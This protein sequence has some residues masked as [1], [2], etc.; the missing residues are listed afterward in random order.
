MAAQVIHSFAVNDFRT[1]MSA[2]TRS[3]ALRVLRLCSTL[4]G[5]YIVEHVGR[6]LL[7]SA[8]SLAANFRSACHAKSSPDFFSK[9][10]LCEEKSIVS[11]FWLD[12]IIDGQLCEGSQIESLKTE[13]HE[14]ASILS[15]TCMTLNNRK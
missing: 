6:Q 15:K 12:F 3:F 13:A 7:R 2:R 9:L 1:D 10:K 8:S 5:D 4:H 14:L 11:C